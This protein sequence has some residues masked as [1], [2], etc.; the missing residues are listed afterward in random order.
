LHAARLGEKLGVRRIV[1]P[2]EAGVGSA[3]GFLL[4]PVAFEVVRS[5]RQKLSSLQADLINGLMRDMHEEALAVVRQGSDTPELL[6][7]RQAYMRYIGQGHEIAVSLPVENYGDDH[8]AVF[9]RAFETAYTRLYS[10]TIDGI[11]VEVLSWTLT[12][13]APTR[14]VTRETANPVKETAPSPNGRQSLFDPTTAVRVDA[15]VYLRDQLSPGDCVNGPALITEDQT[16]TVVTS[17]Y[18]AAIDGHGYIVL[19]HRE[20]SDDE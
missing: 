3:V 16:T 9:L 1:V 6:E 14:K 4:A 12:I 11:D 7:T 10:R 5:R 19:T 17:S 15:P 2:M 18:N 20:A 8:A 13:S